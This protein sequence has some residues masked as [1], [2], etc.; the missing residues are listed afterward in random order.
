MTEI[1]E[2]RVTIKDVEYDVINP[3]GCA[4]NVLAPVKRRMSRGMRVTLWAI[5]LTA[6]IDVLI[7]LGWIITLNGWL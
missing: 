5:A 3:G 6:L 4:P 1:K 2:N 7:V